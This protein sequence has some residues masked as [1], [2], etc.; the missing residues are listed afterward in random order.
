MAVGKKYGGRVAGT[1]NK[2]TKTTREFVSTL[3]SL[4]QNDTKDGTSLMYQDFLSLEP[5]DRITIAEK[6]MQYTTPKY[7]AIAVQTSED[8]KIT[9]E[10]RIMELA[11]V[12]GIDEQ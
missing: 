7:A 5:K 12:P 11:K 10:Q 4:Y 2:T 6:L 1:P 9:I 3:L 8:H